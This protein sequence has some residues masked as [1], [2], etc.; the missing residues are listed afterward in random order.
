MPNSLAFLVLALWPLAM[1]G[2]FRALPPGRALIWSVLASYLLLPPYPTEFD[3]PLMPSLDKTTIPNIMA[4]V[5]TVFY[6]RQKIKWLPDTML[7]K[8][9]VAIF[10][11]APIPTVLTN[12][13]PIV[14][15]TDMLRGLY[16]QDIF[17]MMVMQCILLANFAL[18]RNLLTTE[19]DLR[20]LLLAMVIAGTAYAFPMLIEV[21][22]SPQINIWVYG[23]FQHQFDQMIRGDGFRPIVFLSHGIWAAML[24]MMSLSAAV[25]LVANTEGEARRKLIWVAVFLAAVL[26]L[27]K[28]LSAFMYA[29][30]I[31]SMV[32]FTGWRMQAKVAMLLACLALAYPIAKGANLVPEERL[33]ELAT[34]VSADRAQSLEFRFEHEGALLHRAQEK[35]LF[36]W[37]IWGRNQIHDPVTGRMTSV[38]DGR[39]VLTLGM[40]GWLG[41]IGE[42]GLL[43]LPIFLIYRLSTRLPSE[44][45][46]RR[47]QRE[48]NLFPT[49]GGLSKP[50]KQRAVT[51]IAGG[52]SLLLA[53]NTIDLLPNATLTTMTWLI[54]GALLGYAEAFLAR[55]PTPKSSE[56]A[57]TTPET[58]VRPR[59]VL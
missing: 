49:Q 55:K 24:V 5:L 15:V 42:F 52:L 17:A 27:A 28:T 57:T 2:I 38:A 19:K 29:I 34:S 35:P 41:F 56:V 45:N 48:M 31:V 13:E 25:I 30:F 21:R 33:L 54:A 10:V 9:L 43:I 59:T 36:G 12:P 26:V 14:F 39:W 22:L 18:A 23:F 8:A 51:P 1:L 37:G 32:L 4:I 46:W 47:H 40:L 20:D 50:L 53:I 44:E 16:A 6:A 11:L 58:P 3:F 7:G